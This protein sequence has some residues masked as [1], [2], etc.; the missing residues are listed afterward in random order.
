MKLTKTQIRQAADG[1]A[2]RDFSGF[3]RRISRLDKA[4]GRT[5]EMHA[6]AADGDSPDLIG[7]W[8]DRTADDAEA[9]A[10]AGTITAGAAGVYWMVRYSDEEVD[11]ATAEQWFE[12]V[13]GREADDDD[14]EAGVFSLV[15]AAVSGL[16]SDPDGVV[17]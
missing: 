9:L 14:R 1:L 7:G 8:I 15:C 10:G 17:W 16:S 4:V 13:Y 12:V 5:V 6:E 11:E 3:A 2:P